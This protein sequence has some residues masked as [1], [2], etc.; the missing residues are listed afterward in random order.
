[1]GGYTYIYTY[2]YIYI[3]LEFGIPKELVSLIKTS[4]KETYSKV[5]V[6]KLLSDK[7]PIQNGLKQCDVLLPLLFNFT[8]V[9]D[10]RKVKENEVD[11]KLNAT[12]AGR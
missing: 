4:L 10:I 9:Y 2:I 6:D 8:L 1:M 3:L 12:F 5:R 11:L 7:F